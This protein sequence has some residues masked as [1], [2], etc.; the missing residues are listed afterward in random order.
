M[1]NEILRGYILR[2]H[3][4]S[5]EKCKNTECS[6][7]NE[8]RQIIFIFSIKN[9]S[10]FI[11]STNDPVS[12]GIKKYCWESGVGALISQPFFFQVLIG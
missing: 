9:L 1:R 7:S 10:E 2:V 11:E 12:S 6:R 5:A 8:N 4:I 3:L